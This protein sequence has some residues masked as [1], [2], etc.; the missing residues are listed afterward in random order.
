MTENLVTNTNLERVLNQV[1]DDDDQILNGGFGQQIPYLSW[2]C[3]T[4]RFFGLGEDYCLK[5]IQTRLK[6][7]KKKSRKD[8][9]KAKSEDQPVDHKAL[10]KEKCFLVWTTKMV[11][12][13]FGI[14]KEIPDYNVKNF[15][16]EII[17]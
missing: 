13:V 3:Y 10:V 8:K 15:L 14:L 12:T 6:Q 2:E 16:R 9:K 4:E 11:K 17:L 7:W 5:L 1:R